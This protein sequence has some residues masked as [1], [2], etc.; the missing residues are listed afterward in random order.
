MRSVSAKSQVLKSEMASRLRKAGLRPT[1]QR[2]ALSSLLFGQGD[3]H[4]TAEA[5]H[6]EA[7]AAGIELSLAT[8]YNTLHQFT[9]AGMLR[10][11]TVGGDKAYFDTNTGD[12]HHFYVDAEQRLIDIPGEKVEV[13]GLPTPPAGSEVERV[14]VIVRIKSR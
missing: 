12:H 5:L 4:V 1:R 3:R 11:V 14:D 9:G 10:Q 2:L 6:C 8:V 13:L 7:Q